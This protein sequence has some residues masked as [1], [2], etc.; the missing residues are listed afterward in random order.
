MQPI[1]TYS[2]KH[3]LQSHQITKNSCSNDFGTQQHSTVAKTWHNDATKMWTKDAAIA[4]AVGQAGA[5][6]TDAATCFCSELVSNMQSTCGSWH[7]SL[8]ASYKYVDI[9]Y[10]YTQ[11]HTHTHWFMYAHEMENFKCQAYWDLAW[12]LPT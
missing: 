10:M 2:L 4:S 11:L 7:I 5:A 6:E 12:Q 9:M 3:V 1:H 8:F